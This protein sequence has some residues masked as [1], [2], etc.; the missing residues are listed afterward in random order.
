MRGSM[1]EY[2]PEEDVRPG[3]TRP[4]AVI[5]VVSMQVQQR[6]RGSVLSKGACKK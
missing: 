2:T 1:A 6:T 3:G 5:T 4:K